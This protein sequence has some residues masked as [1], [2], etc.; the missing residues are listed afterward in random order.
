MHFPSVVPPQK[1]RELPLSSGSHVYTSAPPP[2][3]SGNPALPFLVSIRSVSSPGHKSGVEVSCP[4]ALVCGS[5]SA[6]LCC[7]LSWDVPLWNAESTHSTDYGVPRAHWRRSLSFDPRRP[8][9]V[10][11]HRSCHCPFGLKS[12]EGNPGEHRTSPLNYTV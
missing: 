10:S 9:L 7:L 2:S 4:Q 1:E 11:S 8:F 3:G 12:S 5:A 6:C